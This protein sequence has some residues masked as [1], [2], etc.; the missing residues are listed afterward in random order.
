VSEQQRQAAAQWVATQVASAAG[1]L[2]LPGILAAVRRRIAPMSVVSLLVLCAA[3]AAALMWPATYRSMGT[4]LIEQQELPP[5][6]VQSTIT[7]FADQR[8]Q[9]TSQR[10]MT[11]DNLLRIINR[12]DLYAEMRHSKP[13]EVVI[14]QMR[15]DIHLQ[16]ISADVIDPRQGHPTKANIAFTVSY[17]SS[18][19]D[20]AARVANEI[21]SLYLDENA[22]TRRQLTADA[23]HFLDDEANKLD[24]HI[25]VLEANISNFKTRHLETLP[26]QSAIN[27]ESLI[28]HQDEMQSIDTQLNSVNQQLTYLDAQLAQLQPN[29]QVYTSTGERVMS[30]ADRLKYLRSEYAR[31]SGV[32]SPDHPD[33]L[34]IKEQM[35]GL[36]QEAGAVDDRNELQRQLDDDRAALV[37]LRQ[38]D[39]E[40]HPDVQRLQRQVDELTRRI[41]DLPPA[42]STP[43][44]VNPD[45]PP[46]IQLKA[47]REATATQREALQQRRAEVEQKLSQL[48]TELSAAPGVEREFADLLR[49]L[50]NEQ[51]KYREVRQ[52]QMGAKLS[53]N[54]EDEQKGE[55][56]TLIDPPQVPEEPSTPNRKLLLGVGFVVA[57]AAGLLTAMM[58]EGGDRTLRNRNE[59]EAFLEV[60]PLAILPLIETRDDRIR[61]LRRRWMTLASA[62][63]VCVLALLLTHWLYRPLDFLWYAAVHRLTG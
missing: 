32:Y 39:S 42:R 55:R 54:L 23:E 6:L 44:P 20:V 37:Q 19:P 14:A 4:I 29:S 57:L 7:S 61:Q 47:Q 3:C 46:Y 9:V 53:E 33:V 26:E 16:M 13:R 5:D 1:G 10:V 43:P 31:L 17:D 35:D 52:K 40:E 27:K 15:K 18:R 2:S 22:K 8:I 25:A 48:E 60:A 36:Q 63:G 58:L 12:Y 30:S 50:E 21:I 11:T 45:N 24:K 62:T 59:L 49:E 56:F 34:R 28:R 51:I 41:S 38:V